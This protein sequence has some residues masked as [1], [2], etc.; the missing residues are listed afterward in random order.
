[1]CCLQRC[2]TRD[3]KTVVLKDMIFPLCE[4]L[5]Q[6][7]IFVRTR[8]T[9]RRLHQHVR[10]LVHV[11]NC[12]CIAT[13]CTFV[14]GHL[15]IACAQGTFPDCSLRARAINAHP[16][17]ATWRR[18]TAT[19]LWRS[20]ALAPPRSSLPQMSWLAALTSPRCACR[21]RSGVL[22]SVDDVHANV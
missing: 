6:T 19:V 14:A 20:F 7:I 5:G 3:D 11:T 2:P 1:M 21:R 17:K 4:K 10:R 13:L 22:H 9:A 16:F 18:T 8:D 15:P 12:S